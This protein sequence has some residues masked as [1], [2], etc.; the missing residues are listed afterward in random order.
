MATTVKAGP[1]DPNRS[2]SIPTTSSP[3]A[4]PATP[5]V[6][7]RPLARALCLVENSSGP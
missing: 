7:I 4:L 3:V 5:R 2:A 6:T 1:Y